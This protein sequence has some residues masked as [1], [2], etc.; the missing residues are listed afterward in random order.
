MLMTIIRFRRVVLLLLA[1]CATAASAAP[2]TKVGVMSAAGRDVQVVVR[3]PTT[4]TRL[5]Q[6]ARDRLQVGDAIERIVLKAVAD[7]VR[8]HGY[9]EALPLALP[10]KGSMPWQ[11]DGDA[12]LVTQPLF[13]AAKK[14]GLSHLLLIQPARGEA[15]LKLYRSSS[16]AGQLE[17]LGFY[18]DTMLEVVREDNNQPASGF[19][20]PYVYVDMLLVDVATLDLQA[21]YRARASVA[22]ADPGRQGN[23]PWQALST[24]RKV[25]AL[26]YLIE[27]ETELAV[28][29]WKATPAR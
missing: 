3:A 10:A 20:A 27:E 21:I 17:G 1:A 9:G 4:G 12:V 18:V 22:V 6:N 26:R 24:E 19:L 7:S 5:D 23:D 28:Q 13:D 14:A 25:D 16:G 11:R 15:N 2:I 29:Q 8:R